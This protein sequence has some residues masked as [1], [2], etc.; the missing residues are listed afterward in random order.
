MGI[1]TKVS[2]LIFS[3]ILVILVTNNAAAYAIEF[4]PLVATNTDDVIIH[5]GFIDKP[6]IFKQ[7]ISNKESE[8]VDFELKFATF[9]H[10][11]KTLDEQTKP[12]Q[13]KP[14]ETKTI[15]YQFIPT[16]EGNYLTS[17]FS[18]SS[19][20]SI[21]GNSDAIAYSVLDSIKTYEKKTV[22]MYSDSS[23]NDC[24]VLCTNPAEL[25]ITVGTVVEW[26]SE[27]GYY[28]I[29]TG[30]YKE[31]E[32]GINWSFDK[33]LQSHNIGPNKKFSYLFL[34]PGEYQYF[35]NEHRI[36]QVVGTIYVTPSDGSPITKTITT[37]QNI[38]N[39]KNSTI[40]ITS[41]SVN[42]KNSIITVGLD[43]RKEPYLIIDVYKKMIY[44]KVGPV[45][46]NIVANYV[47]DNAT[48][49]ELHEK[50]TMPP[51]LK[52]FKSGIPIEEIQCKE[53][54]QLVI[55]NN[56]NPACVK[57][58]SLGKLY[59]RGW[60]DCAWNCSHEI[61]E[62]L[63][64]SQSESSSDSHSGPKDLQTEITGEDAWTI[65]SVLRIPCPSEPAFKGAKLDDFTKSVSVSTPDVLYE[66]LL[67]KTH[68]CVTSTQAKK[69]E[70]TLR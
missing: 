14:D 54:L 22:K 39:D 11:D 49:Q 26:V 8:P 18:Q 48:R 17:V 24:S 63:I 9:T 10:D 34:E 40:P 13:L 61:P 2:V 20:G 70:C 1:Y 42:P 44:N 59:L 12:V 5:E 3:L 41:L 67:N 37:L 58:T 50:E 28:S 15:T 19:D 35:R 68:V 65:C 4:S 55:K 51:P 64:E 6:I 7:T 27:S 30:E 32:N 53:N 69:T 45:Y 31:E 38:M 62:K 29:A 33:R 52:Q 43:D 23:D 60:G 16:K 56:G 47:S 57:S 66:I 46:L 25:T 36:L 21:I